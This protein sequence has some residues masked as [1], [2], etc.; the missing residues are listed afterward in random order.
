MPFSQA[1]TGN[2]EPM[3]SQTQA[4]PAV[5]RRALWPSGRMKSS[6]GAAYMTATSVV[7]VGCVVTAMSPGR[8]FMAYAFA[9]SGSAGAP[10][11]PISSGQMRCQS[12]GRRSQRMTVRPVACSMAAQ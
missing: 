6:T 1:S 2:S 11:W 3:A 5:C 12:S 10:V 8:Q 7:S 4:G 9:G